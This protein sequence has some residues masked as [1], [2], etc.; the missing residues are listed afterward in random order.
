MAKLEIGK[1]YKFEWC[2]ITKLNK[3]YLSNKYPSNK[4]EF[5]DIIMTNVE[6]MIDEYKFLRIDGERLKFEYALYE[7]SIS[8]LKQEVMPQYIKHN[9]GF[10]LLGITFFKP[11]DYVK[12]T[13]GIQEKTK[14]Y[15]MLKDYNINIK[16]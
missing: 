6:V 14:E 12:G 15:F 8:E 4:N 2:V 7:I 13:Y 5:M 11:Y 9:D 16:E 10:K 1:K 3:I